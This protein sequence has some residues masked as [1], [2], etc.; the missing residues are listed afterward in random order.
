MKALFKLA[1]VGVLTH[2]LVKM[3]RQ[4]KL[5][6]ADSVPTVKPLDDA[7]AT[8]PEPSQPEDL[9]IAPNSPLN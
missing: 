6:A 1:L 5:A 2:L 3:S 8:A 7:Y 4:R 9:R